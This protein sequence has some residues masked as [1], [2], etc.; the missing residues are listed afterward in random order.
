MIFESVV[1]KKE[2]DNKLF[3]Y[4]FSYG[5][6]QFLSLFCHIVIT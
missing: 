2:E 4:I 1:K 5:K 6:G 3:T